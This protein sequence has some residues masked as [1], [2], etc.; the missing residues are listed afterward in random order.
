M[1]LKHLDKTIKFKVIKP[2][3]K[4]VFA[5]RYKKNNIFWV[6]LLAFILFS[7]TVYCNIQCSDQGGCYTC[8]TIP[9]NSGFIPL[10]STWDD[11]VT[12]PSLI[13]CADKTKEICCKDC[14]C[15][16]DTS[17]LLRSQKTNTPQKNIGPGSALPRDSI[18]KEHVPS[19]FF[20]HHPPLQTASIYTLIQSFLC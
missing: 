1:Q 13:S 2:L 10:Y 4:R 9:L 3:K 16:S 17:V 20:T 5:M 8:R 12:H 19:L 14:L 6:T 11:D 18:N 15:T 7:G